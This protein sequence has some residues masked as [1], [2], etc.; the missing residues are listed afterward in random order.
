MQFWENYWVNCNLPSEV[1]PAFSF[2]RCLGIAIKKNLP[3]VCGKVLEVGCAPSKWLA[4]MAKEFGLKPSGVKYS[5][6]G[7]KATLENFRILNLTPDAILTGD[8]FRMKF[9]RQFYAV[10]S[11]EQDL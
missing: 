3:P 6:A 1:D 2:D 10:M 7:M 4:I 8:F 5:Q 9:P 11:Y